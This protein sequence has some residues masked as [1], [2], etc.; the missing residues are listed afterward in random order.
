[1]SYGL[2]LLKIT[3]DD[4]YDTYVKINWLPYKE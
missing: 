3:Q 4:F 1:M 2:N